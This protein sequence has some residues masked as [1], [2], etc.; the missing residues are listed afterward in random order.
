MRSFR[1]FGAMSAAAAVLVAGGEAA[2]QTTGATRPAGQ[3]AA[4][5]PGRSLVLDRAAAVKLPQGGAGEFV[6][7]APSA[8]VY[9]IETIGA[10][11][12]LLEARGPE[13]AVLG[14]DDDGGEGNNARLVLD[15][16]A[17]QEVALRVGGFE[18]AGGKTS[19]RASRGGTLARI[20][21]GVPLE[22]WTGETLDL[23]GRP[24]SL[25]DYR[26]KVTLVDFWAT[27]CGPCMQELPNV[28]AL[29]REFGGRGFD[30]LGISLDNDLGTLRRSVR[31]RGIG[32][33][34]I[35][36]GGGWQSRLAVFYGV[37]SIPTTVLLDR[38]G[39]IIAVDLRGEALRAK[40]LEALGVGTAEE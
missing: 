40:V 7:R 29:H 37:Q 4:R 32:W 6:F 25:A 5:T 10:L 30:I 19:L 9:T 16:R 28:L 13:G 18:G 14:A 27:W 2:G 3:A 12:T 15:L 36:D 22:A 26:G 34:Q 35:A 31:E 24:V 23:E 33:R 1:R 38:E 17:G 20:R 8:G 21:V 39:K 11:D